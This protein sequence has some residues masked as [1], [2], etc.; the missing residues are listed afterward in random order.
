MSGTGMP[1]RD[2]WD[3]RLIDRA[4]AELHGEAPPDVTQR[5]LNRLA[6][7]G[8]AD[9]QTRGERRRGAWRAA[10]AATL[11]GAAAAALGVLVLRPWV[12]RPAQPRVRVEVAV[13]AGA[14]ECV[15]A[16]RDGTAERR[17]T[18]PAG[19]AGG[20]TIDVDN[21]LAGMRGTRTHFSM[22]P[23]GE[24]SMGP[25]T[26]LEVEA[27]DWSVKNGVVVAGA[28]T[29]VVVAGVA[30]W[31]AF[32]RSETAAAGEVLRMEAQGIQAPAASLSSENQRLSQ[33]NQ[34]LKRRVDELEAHLARRPVPAPAAGAA[35][36][37][38]APEEAA[39]AA[40]ATLTF[41]DPKFAETL[42]KIDWKKMGA[43]TAEMG[44]KLVEL[45]KVMNEE[46]GEMPMELAVEVQKL[47][48]Q[49][50]AEVPKL[51]EAGLPGFGVNGVYTHP[52]VSSNILASTLAEGGHPLTKAQ[53]EALGG[54]V[55]AYS[56]ENLGIHERG[57]E[58]EVERVTAETAMKDRFYEEA[59]ALLGPEQRAAVF[60]PSAGGFDGSNLFSSGLVW[61]TVAKPVH[62]ASPAEFAE[63]AARG[64]QK[65]LSLDDA[66]AAQVREII[67]KHSAHPDLWR[68]TERVERALNF[69]AR[70]RSGRAA[71]AQIAWM[72][73]I[74]RSLPLSAEQKEKLAKMDD[75][76]VP[77]PR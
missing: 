37:A 7:A 21:R 50:L 13:H 73:E 39:P 1:P 4:L 18:V 70:G 22:F 6:G 23:F 71:Q 19:A 27:M 8:P 17:A 31:Q 33:E 67:A 57:F 65:R 3:D 20:W 24:V 47:N 38:A 61:A 63:D 25:A 62:A 54:L 75:V 11:L 46:D 34:E 45:A 58:S 74:S 36:P 43:V 53:E 28:V 76:L 49:L 59:A 12:G 68:K 64:L 5:V 55:R 52:L 51:M 72:R 44:P 41:A 48:T 35:P 42:E 26:E 56:A 69:M 60:P 9:A 15:E 29:F 30:T 16:A 77:M 40:P 66:A 10:V 2:S 32:A 14:L